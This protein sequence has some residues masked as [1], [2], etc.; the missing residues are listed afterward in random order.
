MNDH[1]RVFGTP[2][3][4]FV[5]GDFQAQAFNVTPHLPTPR[6]VCG[7]CLIAYE[8]SQ[9]VIAE[10]SSVPPEGAK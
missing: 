7:L 8:W 3:V 6:F 9:L 2:A 1:H 5:C 10:V 4:C